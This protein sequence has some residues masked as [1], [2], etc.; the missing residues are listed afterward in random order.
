MIW[1]EWW[2]RMIRLGRGG[3][4]DVEVNMKLFSYVELGFAM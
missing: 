2:K 4:L 3:D 1:E